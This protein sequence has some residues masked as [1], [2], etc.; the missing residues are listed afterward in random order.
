MNNMLASMINRYLRQGR[1]LTEVTA[2]ENKVKEL[3][4]KTVNE[5]LRKYFDKSKMI[6][7]NSG[8]F[9]KKGF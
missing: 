5:A 9:R 1:D 6:I 3:D 2:M 8:D 7:I 4:V